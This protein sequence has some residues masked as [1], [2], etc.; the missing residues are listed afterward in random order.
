MKKIALLCGLAVV[1]LGA[2]PAVAQDVV[3]SEVSQVA[4]ERFAELEAE[5]ATLRS[6]LYRESGV[7]Y[8]DGG[9][10]S[11]G[12][13]GCNSCGSSC[14][15]CCYGGA[16]VYFGAEYISVRPHVEGDVAYTISEGGNVLDQP[17]SWDDVDTARFFLGYNNDCGYGGRLR[18]WQFDDS[19]NP[20]VGTIGAAQ[21]FAL[22]V[23]N[24]APLNNITSL[25]SNVAGTI[26]GAE[27]DIN[28]D[29]LDMEITKQLRY[30]DTT[31]MFASG[32]RYAEIQQQYRAGFAAA[33]TV[34]AA[35]V[36]NAG[37]IHTHGI[38]AIGP[39]VALEVWHPVR[40]SRL[41]V[42]AGARGSVLFGEQ[43][44]SWAIDNGVAVASYSRSN[45]D[46]VVPVTEL[47]VGS[48]YDFDSGLFIRGGWEG[49]IWHG[50]GG[51][52]SITGDLGFDGFSFSVGVVR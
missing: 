23:N 29:V 31:F 16:G 36:V 40:S 12:G 25:Q 43:N 44:Q 49:Q 41:S 24:F 6:E 47:H 30:R 1:A 45:D 42:Y 5:V 4:Y 14:Y 51:P 15:D 50:A 48:Q 35:P 8:G 27:Y 2:Q 28:L 33:P 18:Y 13:G 20:Q 39:T 11:C 34:G 19:A 7:I 37:L 46:D 9:C 3:D 10:D 52:N 32:V 38:D 17:F 26:V 21:T 22:T